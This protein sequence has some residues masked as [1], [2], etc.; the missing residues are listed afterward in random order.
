[1]ITKIIFFIIL[2]ITFCGMLYDYYEKNIEGKKAFRLS[3]LFY[4]DDNF[5]QSNIQSKC[6]YVI[7]WIITISTLG[8][9]ALSFQIIG[10]GIMLCHAAC[11]AVILTAILYVGF[12]L[13][14]AFVI[15]LISSGVLEMV[16]NDIKGIF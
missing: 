5:K 6:G 2:I 4:L 10:L 14:W 3:K 13:P 11:Y 12:I 8:V 15:N 16:I 9:M 7:L 1:M